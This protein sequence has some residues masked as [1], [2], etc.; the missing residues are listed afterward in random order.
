M[1]KKV[2]AWMSSNGLDEIGTRPVSV[3]AMPWPYGIHARAVTIIQHHENPIGAHERVFTE[4]EVIEMLHA[5]DSQD[6]LTAHQVATLRLLGIDL[7][8]A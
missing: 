1:A 8:P 2:Q 6:G 4:S 5:V 3:E 7:D